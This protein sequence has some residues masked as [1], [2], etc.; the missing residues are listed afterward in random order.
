MKNLDEI[1]ERIKKVHI[2]VEVKLIAVS[3]N[4]T[5]KEVLELFNEGQIDFGENRVQELKNKR[6]ILAEILP[7]NLIKWHFIGR[8]QSNKINQ[9]ISLRPTLWQSCESLKAALEVDKRLDYEL[10]CLLQIN[11]AEEESKQGVEAKMAV[12]TFLSIKESCKFLRPVGVMSIGAHVDDIKSIQKSFEITHKIYEEL[13]P[14]GA[15]IC[16]MGMSGDFE[17][18]IKCGSNMVRLGSVLYK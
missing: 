13:E 11:S 2:G 15:K 3:K 7:E 14:H 18:A 10:E 8:L 4:V 17:L 16:S 1:L 9:L 12:E 6:Q 5:T